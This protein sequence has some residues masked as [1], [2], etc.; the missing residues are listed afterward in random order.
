M[1]KRI[2]RTRFFSMSIHAHIT[3]IDVVKMHTFSMIFHFSRTY[4]KHR[5]LI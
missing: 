3:V 4:F 2:R 1:E 5:L